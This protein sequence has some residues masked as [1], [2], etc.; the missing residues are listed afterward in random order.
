MSIDVKTV[1]D[2]KVFQNRFKIFAVYFQFLP[3]FVSIEGPLF[4][5]FAESPSA[6]LLRARVSGN[7]SAGIL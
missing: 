6:A 5:I 1:K 3:V 2:R 7:Y 4:L